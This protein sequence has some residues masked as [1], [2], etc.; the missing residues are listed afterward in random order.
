ME[1]NPKYFYLYHY[2]T[3][4]AK[5]WS[6][7]KNYFTTD[8]NKMFLCFVFACSACILIKHYI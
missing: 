4:F 8:L 7:N 1:S 5:V 6:I 2:L 3:A